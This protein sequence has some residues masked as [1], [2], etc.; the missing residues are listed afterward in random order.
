MTRS[1]TSSELN[2]THNRQI[3]KSKHV[4]V[5]SYTYISNHALLHLPPPRPP[6]NDR[7]I[8]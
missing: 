4:S 3:S 6:P 1:V 5:L 8:V 7:K 2:V